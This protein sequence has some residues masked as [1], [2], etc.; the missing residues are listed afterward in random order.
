[1]NG[2]SQVEAAQRRAPFAERKEKKRKRADDAPAGTD[3]AAA[4]AAA[5]PRSPAAPVAAA[6]PADTA[7]ASAEPKPRQ[8]KRPRTERPPGEPKPASSNPKHA[9]VRTVALGNLSAGNLAQALAYVQVETAAHQVVHPQQD[10]LDAHML[11]RDGCAGDVVFLVYPTVK[12]PI[13]LSFG[14][15]KVRLMIFHLAPSKIFWVGWLTWTGP[16]R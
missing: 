11:Q 16:M 14:H 3:E 10:E 9:L 7:A 8:A 4:S 6:A 2:L 1:M 15:G 13:N 12:A 5:G